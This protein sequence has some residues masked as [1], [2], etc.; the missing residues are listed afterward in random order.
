M[1][2]FIA[3]MVQWGKMSHDIDIETMYAPLKEEIKIGFDFVE[4]DFQ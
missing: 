4:Y 3:S 1:I 2:P